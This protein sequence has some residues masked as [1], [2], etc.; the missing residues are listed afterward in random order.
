MNVLFVVVSLFAGLAVALA[1]VGVQKITEFRSLSL[2]D[3]RDLALAKEREARNKRTLRQ[4][5]ADYLLQLGWSGPLAP[6]VWAAA[7]F[8]MLTAV[9]LT[10]A[11]IDGWLGVGVAL[12]LTGLLILMA[13]TISKTRR[14]RAFQMQLVGA[15][16]QLASKLR[17]G[18]SPAR[19]LEDLAP[20]LP[21]PL[22]TE[23]LRAVDAHR[24][25][26][27]LSDAMED[28]ARRYPSR[29][30]SLFVTALRVGELR[31][32]AIATAIETA[33]STIRED[34]ELRAEAQ[35]EVSQEKAQ[36]YA[37]V[38]IIAAIAISTL[39]KSGP[40]A[41]EAFL[42]PLGMIVLA[43]GFGNFGLGVFLVLRK[44]NKAKES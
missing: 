36:F 11:G 42:T 29:P 25:S 23:I 30:M 3:Q 40:E 14:Q 15:F 41:K 35:A 9:A 5:I 44:L 27:V 1:A 16:D 37:I 21:E 18:S 6:I 31:G 26:A 20:T 2:K 7:F 4:N 19:A 39:T 24:S 38:G 22:R 10:L 17:A 8:Y 34:T 28:V 33:A 32:G 43:V 12:P 13:T